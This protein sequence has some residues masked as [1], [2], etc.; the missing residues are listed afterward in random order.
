MP[1]KIAVGSNDNKF[2]NQHFGTSEGFAIY[3]VDDNEKYT[4]S[5][6]RKTVPSCGAKEEHDAK[7][8][9]SV[10]ALTDCRIVLI[11]QVGPCAMAKLNAEGIQF[12]TVTGEIEQ[13]FPKLI[14]YLKK[15]KI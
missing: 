2:V 1:Y 5:E 6:Y 11:N 14:S 4:Y 7:M 10:N 8:L 12:L 15:Q 13:I 9:N 3:I